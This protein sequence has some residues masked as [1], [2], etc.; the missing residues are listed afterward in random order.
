MSTLPGKIKRDLK[1]DLPRPRDKETTDSKRFIELRQICH[2]LI[3]EE[4]IKAL[5]K[6]NQ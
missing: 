1:I 4:S 3:R 5:D 2:S 6:Q